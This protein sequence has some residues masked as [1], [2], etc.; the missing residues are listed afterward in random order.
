MIKVLETI[1]D[2]KYIRFGNIPK[3]FKSKV[4]RGDATYDIHDGVSVWNSVMANDCYFPILPNNPNED[5][6][7]DYFQLLWSD[8]PVYLVTGTEADVVGT[9]GEPLLLDDIKI[10]E[11][12]D[13]SQYKG[14]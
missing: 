8:K 11:E 9:D 5:A 14:W 4:H 3:D 12:L 10:I 2:K 7:A 6:V 1:D 13:Y